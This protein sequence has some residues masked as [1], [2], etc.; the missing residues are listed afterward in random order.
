MKTNKKTISKEKL[1]N[2][3][4]YVGI[5]L[6]AVLL[7]GLIGSLFTGNSGGDGVR[8][9]SVT[10]PVIEETEK[11]TEPET[12]PA[13]EIWFCIDTEDFCVLEGTTWLEFIESEA[14]TFGLTAGNS[15]GEYKDTVYCGLYPLYKTLDTVMIS[16]T[17][18]EGESYTVE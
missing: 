6:A 11:A 12:E 18:I 3:L 15:D 13:R 9:P 10:E 16:D 1:L 2:I 7:L 8:A 4:K 14:N 17:I 5:A